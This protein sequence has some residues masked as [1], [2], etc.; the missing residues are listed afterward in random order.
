[1]AKRSSVVVDIVAWF[2]ALALGLLGSMFGGSIEPLTPISG[3]LLLCLPKQNLLRRQSDW[4]REA[5]HSRA[6]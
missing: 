4:Q 6:L 3:P 1:M 2:V 5:K